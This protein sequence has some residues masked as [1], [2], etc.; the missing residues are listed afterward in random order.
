M[1]QGRVDELQAQREMAGS[2]YHRPVMVE[3]VMQ[4]LIGDLNGIY[5]DATLG[6]AGHTS[7][8]LNHLEDKAAV[9]GLDRDADAHRAANAIVG[10]DK[11]FRSMQ[12]EFSKINRCAAAFHFGHCDGVLADFG[13]SSYQLDTAE[14]G[15]SF[16]QD[17]L[18]D[19]R[20]NPTKGETAAEL[21]QKIDEKGLADMIFQFG[22]EKKSRQIA[23]AVCRERMHRSIQT[24][25]DLVGILDRALPPKNRIKSIARVFQALRI[26]VNDE[27][28]EIDRFLQ[29]AFALLKRGGHLVL[30]TYH[31]LEDRRVKQFFTEKARGCICPPELP[32]CVCDHQ[33]EGRVLTRKVITASAEEVEM[34]PR[35]RSAKLRA[36]E[37]L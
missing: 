22:E 1:S 2:S 31:S 34:N 3:E 13:V 9:I 19:L 4:H 30:L 32:V 10:N 28:G 6:G 15:F 26:A 24:T 33:P 5:I 16:M 36:I 8:L 25:S 12:L 20:M 14:R 23:R 35:A 17:G 27:L 21:L 29:S 7:V 37:K 11:R 18:L